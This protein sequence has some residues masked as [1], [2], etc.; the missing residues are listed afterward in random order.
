LVHQGLPLLELRKIL[1]Y[2]GLLGLLLVLE[3]VFLLEHLGL[4]SLQ[5]ALSL[6]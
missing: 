5:Q 6:L 1:V 4:L 3:E 2:L